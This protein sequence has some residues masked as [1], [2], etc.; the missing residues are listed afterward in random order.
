MTTAPRAALGHARIG[1][2]C[3]AAAARSVARAVAG[4]DA[5]PSGR[6]T[7]STAGHANAGSAGTTGSRR[8]GRTHAGKNFVGGAC[9]LARARLGQCRG[10][11][12]RRPPFPH[13][14]AVRPVLLPPPLLAR[15]AGSV[16]LRRPPTPPTT[17]SLPTGVAALA[18]VVVRRPE[19]TRV[20]LEQPTPAA[21]P[22]SARARAFLTR[23]GERT[24]RWWAQGRGF[25]PD[26][27]SLG[28]KFLPSLRGGLAR[29][30]G[31]VQG[32]GRSFP[33]K[34]RRAHTYQAQLRSLA[35]LGRP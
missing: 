34:G 29:L 14:L 20:A 8:A 9:A 32:A 17:G 25:T 2:A 7:N 19:P 5:L 11:R 10:G 22:R 13:A 1:D 18:G 23:P 27:S 16:T 30:P 6:S 26:R 24:I 31:L 15:V 4:R 33:S 12:G 35:P 3:P 28:G 21:V